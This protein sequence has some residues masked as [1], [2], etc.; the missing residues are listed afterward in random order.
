MSRWD[1]HNVVSVIGLRGSPLGLVPSYGEAPLKLVEVSIAVV[2]RYA[3]GKVVHMASD[4]CS[5]ALFTRVR[6]VAR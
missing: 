6:E 5:E 4:V 2:P 1:K 3:R